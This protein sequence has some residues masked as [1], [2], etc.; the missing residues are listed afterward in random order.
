MLRKNNVT[1]ADKDFEAYIRSQ[2]P[3]SYYDDLKK[4]GYASTTIYK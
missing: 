3:A 2:L 4:K 1:Y